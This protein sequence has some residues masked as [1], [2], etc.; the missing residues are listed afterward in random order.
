[1]IENEKDFITREE[2]ISLVMNQSDLL[3]IAIP[4]CAE[5]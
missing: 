5:L 1:M 3:K 4:P 2:F